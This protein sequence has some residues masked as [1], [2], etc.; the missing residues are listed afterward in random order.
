MKFDQNLAA[1]HAYLCGD[2]YVIKNPENQK[3]KYYYIGL[4]N[5][6]LTLLKDFQSKFKSYFGIEPIITNGIDRC[7]IQ[8][9]AI[10]Y[11]LTKD[12]SFYS[13]EWELPPLSKENLKFW[14]RAFFDCEGWVENQPK[15]S[16]LI[17]LDCC[18]KKG[19]IQVKNALQRLYINSQLTKK[20]NRTI[21][22]LTIC[23]KENLQRYQ[24][25]IG[26]LHPQKKQRL[27]NALGSFMNYAWKIPSDKQELLDFVMERGKFRASRKEIR[28]LSIKKKNLTNLAKALK[29]QKISSTLLGP[30]QSSTKSQYYCL[31]IKEENISWKTKK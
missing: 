7:K 1:I 14:L 27:E 8:N 25:L 22:R 20:K 5:T 17:S 21:W 24:S 30:W 11:Q 28:L 12:Y 16:R 19:I 18:N 15:K 2:G 9:K 4:R 26:F 13:Y 23:G 29:K 31:K 6:N 3:K 10:Y